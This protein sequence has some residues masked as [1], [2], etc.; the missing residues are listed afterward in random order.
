VQYIRSLETL[1]GAV[2]IA[3]SG[4]KGGL[5]RS[6]VAI[7]LAAHWLE[8]GRSVLLVDADPQRT[9]STWLEI[10]QERG[11]AVPTL[12]A[13]GG[14]MYQPTQLPRLAPRFDVVIIDPPPGVGDVQRAALMIADLAVL[15]CGPSA[16]DCWALAESL[17]L[18]EQ[19]RSLRPELEAAILV[20][21]KIARTVL[22]REARSVL[23][24]TKLRVL[25]T[26]IGYRTDYQEASAAG[27]GVTTWQRA[28]AAA[29]EIRSL[30][31][32][33]DLLIGKRSRRRR[34]RAGGG[35]A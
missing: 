4:Q 28:G 14:T 20:T 16:H 10:A 3:L 35:L 12:V 17:Q 25:A 2:I 30:A 22:A 9:V 24:E 34:D 31:G 19:A 11:R 32:E 15:P 23:E 8:K 26:E 5:G 13:M 29:A 18:L 21:K 6:T 33:I 27:A 7:S 1:E